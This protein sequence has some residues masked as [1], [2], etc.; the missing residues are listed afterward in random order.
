MS[1]GYLQVTMYMS[2]VFSSSISKCDSWQICRM[3]DV[4]SSSAKLHVDVPYFYWWFKYYIF[5]VA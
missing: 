1:A 3:V 5:D 2:N 4:S